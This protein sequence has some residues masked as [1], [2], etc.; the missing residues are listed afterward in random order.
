MVLFGAITIVGL[1]ALTAHAA[2]AEIDTGCTAQVNEIPI[3][4]LDPDSPDDAIPVQHDQDVAVSFLGTAD[5]LSYKLQIE[6]AGFRWTA[7]DFD[8][9]D[10]DWGDSVPVADYAKHGVGLYKL[11]LETEN[12]DGS[13]GCGGAVLVDVEADPLS[14]TAGIVGVVVTAVGAVG[15]VASG[16]TATR[17]SVKIKKK[18]DKWLLEQVDEITAAADSGEEPGAEASRLKRIQRLEGLGLGKLGKLRGILTFLALPGLVLAIGVSPMGA[19]ARPGPAA[20]ARLDR[21]HW[22]PRVSVVGV[23]AGLVISAGIVL[24]LQQYSEVYPTRGITVVGLVLGLGVGLTVP[25][26]FRIYDVWRANRTIASAERRLND[27]LRQNQASTEIA[28]PAENADE[29]L[30]ES[31]SPGEVSTSSKSPDDA[32]AEIAPIDEIRELAGPESP[33]EKTQPPANPP[34]DG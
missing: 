9:P 10:P 21:I 16:A 19:A 1:T 7:R 29:T 30:A 14:T 3:A 34:H 20:P 12:R 25:S 31:E 26:F 8:D 22:K 4:G 23:L 17:P 24:L 13:P 15:L 18:I 5:L 28:S 6:F 11:V 32:I 33:Q 27:A 2:R